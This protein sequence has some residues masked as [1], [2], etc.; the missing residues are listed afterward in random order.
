LTKIFNAQTVTFSTLAETITTNFD[1]KQKKVAP[2]TIDLIVDRLPRQRPHRRH[3]SEQ[4]QA[5]LKSLLDYN[6]AAGSKWI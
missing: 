1:Q 6:T 2:K 5:N 4:P 3:L